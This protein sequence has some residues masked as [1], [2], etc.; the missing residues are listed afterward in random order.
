MRKKQIV[1]I[2]NSDSDK[3]V[4]RIAYDIGKAVA[5]RGFVLITGGRTGVMEF[6]S[7]GASELNGTVIGI[8]PGCDFDEANEF[9]D[10]VLPSGIGYARNLSNILAGDL[11]ISICGASGTLCELTYAWKFKKRIVACSFSGGVSSQV[12]GTKL[13]SRR[14]EAIIDAKKLDDV[15]SELDLLM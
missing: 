9:C 13:D 4:S 2:G 5:E 11:V 8:L 10:I 6:A 15:Y 14:E 3:K 12:A 7:K 1:V